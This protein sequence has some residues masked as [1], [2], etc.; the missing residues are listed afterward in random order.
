MLLGGAG[1]DDYVINPLDGGSD[2]IEDT[3]GIGRL[4]VFYG[5]Q[6]IPIAPG[7]STRL[8]SCT[9]RSTAADLPVEY[10]LIPVY[11]IPNSTPVRTDLLITIGTTSVTIRDFLNSNHSAGPVSATSDVAS[12]SAS[13]ITSNTI[14]GALGIFLPGDYDVGTTAPPQVDAGGYNNDGTGPEPPASPGSTVFLSNR[15]Y[16]EGWTNDHWTLK[17]GETGVSLYALGGDDWIR[18][19]DGANFIYGGSGSDRIE[20]NG[21]DDGLVGEGRLVVTDSF[22][23]TQIIPAI[24]LSP[25]DA[26]DVL[27]GGAGHDRILGEIGDDKLYAAD[28]ATYEQIAQR[29]LNQAGSGQVGDYLDGGTQNDLLVGDVGNDILAGGAGDDRIFGGGGDDLIVADSQFRQG[30]ITSLYQYVPGTVELSFTDTT[31]ANGFRTVDYSLGSTLELRLAPSS[32][33]GNDDLHGGQGNDVIYAG[34][35]RDY[36]DGGMGNDYLIGQAGSDQ[37][38]G[39]DGADVIVGDDRSAQPDGGAS[40]GDDTLYGGAGND[41][42]FGGAKDD[43]LVGD[44]GDDYLAG[45]DAWLDAAYQGADILDGGDGNDQLLGFGGD[46]ELRGGA[47]N[48]VLFGD[49]GAVDGDD[50][51][52]GGD[53][54]DQLTGG[55]GDDVLDGGRG[56]DLLEGGAGDDVYRIGTNQGQDFLVDTEG[57]NTLILAMGSAAISVEW[58]PLDAAN[59]T[60]RTGASSFVQLV[61]GMIS[62][63]VDQISVGGETY[64]RAEFINRFVTGP[65]AVS[66]TI[67][68]ANI[69]GGSGNDTLTA[70]GGGATLAGG[71]GND[72]L[73]GQGGNNTYVYNGGDGNDR[74]VD[75]GNRV[76]NGQAAS[77]VLR[78]GEGIAAA[79]LTLDYGPSGVIVRIGEDGE[80]VELSRFSSFDTVG[81]RTIDVF[82]F[83]DGTSLTYAQLLERG[84]DHQGTTGNDTISGS[85]VVD[86]IQGG[87]GNDSIS[88]GDGDDVLN[89]GN[90]NDHL[91]GDSGNN[92]LLGGAGD[93]TY[94]VGASDQVV[95][96]AGEGTDT[97]YVLSNYTLADNLENAVVQIENQD[98]NVTGNALNNVLTG[99]GRANVLDGQAGNDTLTGGVGNDVL[100]GGLGN[101]TMYG[102]S[103]SDTYR[104][105]RGDGTDTIENRDSSANSTDVLQ[106]TDLNA[107]DLQGS[108]IGN[109]LVLVTPPLP[110]GSGGGTITLR[111]YFSGDA[112]DLITFANGAQWTYADAV[113][114]FPVVFT[115]NAETIT[116]TPEDDSYD[117]RGGNDTASGQDGNDTI[118]GGNGN[119]TISGNNGNDLLFG[120]AGDDVL[121][122]GD[123]NDQL[124][125]GTGNDTLGGGAGDDLFLFDR[126][127]GNDTV[128][129]TVG[130]GATE[131]DILRIGAGYTPAD[132]KVEVNASD[133]V[134]RF[135]DSASLTIRYYTVGATYEVDRIEFA[136]GTVWTPTE[137]YARL[138]A[139]TVGGDTVTGFA[140]P[141]TI[142]GQ[143]G[144]D[145]LSGGAGN[146]ILRGGDGIDDVRGDAG[147]DDVAGGSG[148]DVLAGADGNDTFRFGRGDGGDRLTDTAGSDRILLGTGILPTHVTLYRTS[149]SSGAADDLVIV[150]DGGTTQLRVDGFFAASSD[151]AVEQIVFE[152]GTVWDLSTITS[153]AQVVTGTID[154]Q[155]GTSGNDTFTVDHAGDSVSGGA[156]TDLVNSSVNHTL[157][158]DV[159]NLTLTGTFNIDGTGNTLNN[160][161]TG[162]AAN[163]VLRGGTGSDILIG[164]AGDDIYYTGAASTL[165]R[166]SDDLE[167]V[168]EAANEGTDTVIVA[169]YSY[170]LSVNVENLVA[171]WLSFAWQSGGAFV[172]RMFTGNALDNIID[173]SAMRLNGSNTLAPT[174]LDGGQGADTLIGNEAADTYVVDNV[175]D[176]IIELDARVTNQSV[177]TV[178]TTINWT[179]GANLENL[180][181]SGNSAISGTG[182]AQANR[183]EGDQNSAANVLTGGAGDDTYVLGVGDTAV[184]LANEGVDTVVLARNQISTINLG[185]FA[186]IEN[187]ELATNMFGSTLNGTAGNNRLTGNVSGNTIQGGAGDDVIFDTAVTSQSTSFDMDTL[188][189]GEGNDTITSR[190]S[191]DTIIGGLGDDI[192]IG[193]SGFATY[194]YGALDGRDEITDSGGT[195][196]IEFGAGI[197][198]SQVSFLRSGTDLLVRVG[199]TDANQIRVH[200]YFTASG[201]VNS[202]NEIEQFAFNGGPTWGRTEVLA[203]LTVLPNSAASFTADVIGNGVDEAPEVPYLDDTLADFAQRPA[204]RGEPTPLSPWDLV[205][206][207]ASDGGDFVGELDAIMPTAYR[208]LGLTDALPGCGLTPVTQHGRQRLWSAEHRQMN[209]QN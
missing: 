129:A 159:E 64:S 87:D 65:V 16:W 86:R 178:Q 153:M 130:G 167:T 132:V 191:N 187:A 100:I 138:L 123:G 200:N 60:I 194:R 94:T 188:Y 197:T 11:E 19:S 127:Q 161:I 21:G 71:S 96:L 172:Q 59:L 160:T 133:L 186:N 31:D 149:I 151:R 24:D 102:E 18:D 124:N 165:D 48:D 62:N 95:E 17:P 22:G 15:L 32:D 84:F 42:I 34:G 55:G 183:L 72:I 2:V 114:Q 179:L 74:I 27:I 203:N 61:G 67:E 58:S 91:S 101:D 93:D 121:S 99:S 23:Q 97:A 13:V 52:Y 20:G 39:G 63:G 184:E 136:D 177:D 14:G 85:S 82:Q 168:V 162:N 83:A 175:G 195:D 105:A 120:D 166:F 41:Q 113:S 35:G 196:A 115:D 118:R 92:T 38:Y 79:D 170:S 3:D 157:A 190:Y 176:T 154:T 192:L 147:D 44:A 158:P 107:S 142:D 169:T 199:S 56:N 54:D 103:G 193:G 70:T 198:T 90:G 78:F 108:R 201:T 5:G 173:A 182:N 46:D 111:N 53:G 68:H 28:E 104:Y 163:N 202:F 69:A 144:N 66:T 152:N 205:D 36:V 9:W 4:L 109:D 141:D 146:D 6:Y 76:I 117:L 112:V 40:G 180:V 174:R 7:Q 140:R 51:L 150:I 8:D 10:R 45:D 185:D 125:G 29:D 81:T 57:A 77:N 137:I 181:L 47:G 1:Q 89:G 116:G 122:G 189:G 73:T 134:L 30:D 37:M 75:T 145:T 128:I 206:A 148:N 88:G 135:S 171:Q 106:F 43:R 143:G 80:T 207:A 119:D 139:T 49:G 131:T 209:W 204:P 12:R 110:D 208:D 126:N 26:R 155:I 98:V 25:A 33:Q 164:G 50:Q 156:G